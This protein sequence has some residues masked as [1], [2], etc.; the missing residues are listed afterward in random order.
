M[1]ISARIVPRFPARVS[2]TDGV[3]VEKEN[4]AFTVKSDWGALADQATIPPQETTF[5]PL[6]KETGS[7]ARMSVQ[8]LQEYLVSSVSPASIGAATAAQGAKADSAIQEVDATAV[9]LNRFGSAAIG[10]DWT[11]VMETALA[12]GE[13]IL[14]PIGTH[15]VEQIVFDTNATIIGRH[16]RL[17]ILK[18][19]DGANTHVFQTDG[20]DALIG[21]DPT[22]V[23]PYDVTI[24]NLAIDGNRANNT[25]GCGIKA[26]ARRLH[27]SRLNF[28]NIP[29][30]MI[31]MDYSDSASGPITGAGM[32]GMEAIFRDLW[33]DFIGGYGVRMGGPHDSALENI[34]VIHASQNAS[35]T[36]D[37]F[38]FGPG[39]TA[40]ARNLH[41]YNSGGAYGIQRYGLLDEA[42]S[43]DITASHFE[44]SGTANAYLKAPSSMLTNCS[45]YATRN[46]ARNLIIGAPKIYVSGRL[47][48]AASGSTTLPIGVTMGLSGDYPTECIVD[49]HVDT[50]DAGSLDLTYSAG[51]NKITL[52]GSQGGS[53]PVI[54]GNPLS[55]DVIDVLVDGTRYARNGHSGNANLAAG[56]TGASDATALPYRVN[57]V[58]ST[59]GNNGVKLPDSVQYVGEAGG[60]VVVNTTASIIKVYPA[61]SDFIDNAGG[62]YVSVPV[63]KSASFSCSVATAWCA[64]V[65]A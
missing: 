5:I 9:P 35:N 4:G 59:S 63:G 55:T 52:R 25:D 17:S 2:G 33:G 18:L 26:F 60:I 29:E 14:I 51:K 28:Y 42:G 32:L 10:N 7:Y 6:W 61:G 11:L 44:G 64:V 13:P 41:C 21:T 12:S 58:S 30:D 45:F 1:S 24:H 22:D 54:I 47:L 39:M 36:Y 65:S 20:V 62:S 49:L 31:Y 16:Q 23:A 19:A 40:R 57:R 48:P 46:A 34:H 27:L 56:G 38:Y 50:Q 8:L 15:N 3:A 37:A 53:N 43:L